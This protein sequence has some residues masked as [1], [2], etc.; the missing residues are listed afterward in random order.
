MKKSFLKIA[1]ILGG[2]VLLPLLA[3][4]QEKA[5]IAISSIRACWRRWG[6]VGSVGRWWTQNGAP[7]LFL[8]L[9]FYTTRSQGKVLSLLT[10]LSLSCPKTH[11]L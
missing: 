10:R 2:I 3:S 1:F 8:A 11:P 7:F 6:A 4:A 5:T 9:S